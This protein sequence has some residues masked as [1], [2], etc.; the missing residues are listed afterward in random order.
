VPAAAFRLPS[1]SL[2]S[3]FASSFSFATPAATELESLIFLPSALTFLP[4]K[5]KIS[6]ESLLRTEE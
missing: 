3:G 4:L 6:A 1:F 5:N 2:S